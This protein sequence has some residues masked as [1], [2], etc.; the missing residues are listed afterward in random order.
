MLGYLEYVEDDTLFLHL[1]FLAQILGGF[2]AGAN[3]TSSMAILSSFSQ[4]EREKYIGWVEA[5][6]GIG[7]LFGPLLGAFLYS[8]GGYVM[9]FMT[10]GKY[11][12]LFAIS[13]IFFLYLFDFIFHC[14]IATIYLVTF[15]VIIYVLTRAAEMQKQ[16]NAAQ[17]EAVEDKAESGGEEIE[18]MTL[19][20]KPRFTFGLMSQMFITMSL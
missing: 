11:K 16:A 7:L 17:G 14:S 5:S 2:G 13:L 4:T 1:S 20:K 19:L 10:F 6:F 15:P 3:S 18:L 12:T 9:P 8:I